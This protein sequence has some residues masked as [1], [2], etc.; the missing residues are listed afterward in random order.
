MLLEVGTR[1]ALLR[2]KTACTRFKTNWFCLPPLTFR[3]DPGVGVPV[4]V[5][6][7]VYTTFFTGSYCQS[8]LPLVTVIEPTGNCENEDCRTTVRFLF[9]ATFHISLLRVPLSAWPAIVTLRI[10]CNVSAVER[11]CPTF[12]S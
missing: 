7:P 10:A 2:V 4:V 9:G 3:F 8:C 1:V 5:M 12:V 6:G 11:S